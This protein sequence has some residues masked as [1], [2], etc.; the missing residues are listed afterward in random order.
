M[1]LADYFP[2]ARGFLEGKILGIQFQEYIT[3]LIVFLIALLVLR[4]FKYL[5]LQKLHNLAKKTKTKIDDI[6]IESVKDIGWI[7]YIMLSIYTGLFFI[8]IPNIVT[9]IFEYILLVVLVYYAVKFIIAII[10]HSAESYVE[11][12]KSENLGKSAMHL[13]TTF[14][15]WIIWVIAGILVLSHFGVDIAPLIAGLGIGG[16]AIA[17]ALQGVLSDIFASIS[18]ALD[19]PFEVGD[20]I[21]CGADSGTVEKV[22]I[23]SSR[24]RTL[25]GQELIMSNKELTEARVNNYKRMENR[26]IV[27]SVG[28]TYDTPHA[29]LKKIP[30]IVKAI[31]KKVRSTKLDRIHFKEFADSSLNFEIVYYVDDRD[32]AKYMDKQQE[33]NL[34]IVQA[35]QK[36]KI[37]MAFPTR[38]VHMANAKPVRSKRK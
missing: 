17:F 3:A 6:L 11:K 2:G 31:F 38:T 25:Q 9:R 8:G 12:K 24:I 36:E 16:I 22:G 27:F 15:K 20:Y 13:I 28:V 34:A 18:I 7:F 33:I 26:R 21:V 4:L 10:E 14:A 23:K 35:F 5:I 1:S 30:V 19:K 32:Y 29:K 37:E